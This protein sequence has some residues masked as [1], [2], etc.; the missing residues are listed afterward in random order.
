MPTKANP[1]TD[2]PPPHGLRVLIAEEREADVLPLRLTLTQ[3]F[4]PLD[5]LAIG[6]MD[7]LRVALENG[8]WDVL[9]V[10]AANERCRPERI[11]EILV[12]DQSALPLIVLGG[13]GASDSGADPVLAAGYQR[14]PR[15]EPSLLIR[16]V[17]RATRVSGSGRRR[18]A[19]DRQLG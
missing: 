15:D 6:E 10:D 1:P 7:A 8:T 4:A 13:D 11:I 17:E 2:G 16:A 18:R 14:V 19:A 3:A 12:E 5:A 9:I